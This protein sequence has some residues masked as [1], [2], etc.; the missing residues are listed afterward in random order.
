MVLIYDAATLPAQ[1]SVVSIASLRYDQ[2]LEEHVLDGCKMDVARLIKKPLQAHTVTHPAVTVTLLGVFRQPLFSCS[3]GAVSGSSTL[4]PPT[5]AASSRGM[6]A[7]DMD[8]GLAGRTSP[9][10]GRKGTAS[11]PLPAT[12]LSP[13]HIAEAL[14]QS[15][16]NGATLDLTH[17]NLTDV[18][19]SG[20]QELAT[21]G[22]EDVVEDESSVLRCVWMMNM[23][24]RLQ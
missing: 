8:R 23:R 11:P 6:P 20:A 12:S 2:Q 1:I 22:R 19:E 21:I 4:L 15:P 18:G 13:A 10:P 24:A 16:D 17:K 14:V 5:Q 7:A 3:S 9:H